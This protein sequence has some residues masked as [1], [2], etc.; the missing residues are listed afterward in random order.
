[1]ARLH[2]A[3]DLREIYVKFGIDLARAM[4]MAPGGSYPR[5]VRH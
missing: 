1:M 5:P 3:D 2:P 4:A